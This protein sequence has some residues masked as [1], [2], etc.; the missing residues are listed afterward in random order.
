[1]YYPRG[2]VRSHSA[3]PSLCPGPTPLG[4]L[5]PGLLDGSIQVKLRNGSSLRSASPSPCG[6][7]HVFSLAAL[8]SHPARPSLGAAGVFMGSS[9]RGTRV[10]LL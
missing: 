8:D 5:T 2:R 1:M 9:H 4:R 7:F 6:H 10:A 3:R